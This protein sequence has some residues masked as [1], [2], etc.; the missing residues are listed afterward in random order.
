M[1]ICPSW[2]WAGTDPK[3]LAGLIRS[4]PDPRVVADHRHA[5]R[6]LQPG[7]A[8]TGDANGKEALV[9]QLTE[10]GKVTTKALKQFSES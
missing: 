4:L 9:A 10:G 6:Q 1:G 8:P 5:P 2:E 3:H 7:L